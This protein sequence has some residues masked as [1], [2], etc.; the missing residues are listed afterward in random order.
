MRQH[1][2][3]L[4][5]EKMWKN[6]KVILLTGDLGYGLVDKIQEVMPEQFINCGASEQAMLGIGVGLA[7]QGYIPVCYSITPFLLWRGAE[8]IRNYI[9]AEEIP[10]K[11]IG[12][13][14]GLDYA[15]D[16]K[17]HW[18]DDDEQLMNL[19]ENIKSFWP[20]SIENM[21]DVM[22]AMFTDNKP[23]YINLKRG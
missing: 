1:F 10:V 17:T 16:G 4:L 7:L 22:N 13:G 11:L 9:N 6:K 18:A 21:E 12:S 8:W 5:F 3:D 2:F 19:F 14:R 20:V 23:Y 15:H